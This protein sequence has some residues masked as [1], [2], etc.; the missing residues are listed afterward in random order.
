MKNAVCESINYNNAMTT[1]GLDDS[2]A[3]ELTGNSRGRM[4][5]MK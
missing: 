3:S 4:E 2:F 5:E 1:G